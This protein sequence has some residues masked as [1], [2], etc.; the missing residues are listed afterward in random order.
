MEYKQAPAPR[1]STLIA[2]MAVVVALIWWLFN[3]L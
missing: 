1:L 3:R 2:M